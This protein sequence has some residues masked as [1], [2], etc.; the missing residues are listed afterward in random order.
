MYEDVLR[1]KF[2]DSV[3]VKVLRIRINDKANDMI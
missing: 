1:L 2:K 3:H